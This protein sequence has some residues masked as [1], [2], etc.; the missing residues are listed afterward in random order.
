M[1]QI[2]N[3]T[4]PTMGGFGSV[5]YQASNQQEHQLAGDMLSELMKRGFIADIE[6]KQDEKV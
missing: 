2:K 4:Q 6:V 3:I 5:E 1:I